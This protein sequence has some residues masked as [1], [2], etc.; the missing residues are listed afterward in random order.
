M[1]KGWQ[2]DSEPIIVM[3]IDQVNIKEKFYLNYSEIYCVLQLCIN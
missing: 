3:R 1:S 2:E